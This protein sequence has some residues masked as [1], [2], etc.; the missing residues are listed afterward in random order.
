[1]S[2]KT[3]HCSHK[4][5]GWNKET[6]VALTI[7]PGDIVELDVSDASDGIIKQNSTVS[8]VALLGGERANPLIG[9]IFIEDAKVGDVLEVE[10]ID[11]ETSN[12]GWTAIIP[13]FGLLTK[14][15][16]TAH[17]HISEY[18]DKFV[19]FTSDIL[20]PVK[21]FPGTIGV[22]PS[23]PGTHSVI[24]PRAVGGNLDLRDITKGAKVYLPVAVDG[25]LLS[26][27]DT[28]AAQGDGEVCGTAVESSMKIKVSCRVIKNEPIR[29]PRV[30]TPT[31][32]AKKEISAQYITTGI[33]TSLE[34][35]AGDAI[36]EMIDYLN[37]EYKLE[38]EVAY[39][40]CSVAVNLRISEVVNIPNWVVSASLPLEI[41]R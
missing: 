26:I 40:L 3:I 20:I 30:L 29:T 27:G 14:D 31:L 16:S 4:H 15:F 35:A 23:E 19:Y 5:Y 17:L 10:I 13:E 12:W 28:H 39:C 2:F 36:K 21:P 33:G 38:P 7:S 34:Q 24:P 18:D 8:D 41:F 22:S 9:P 11:F 1:M 32:S 6:P 37:K 25:A